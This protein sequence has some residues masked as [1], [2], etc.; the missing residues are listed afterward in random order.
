[1]TF[2]LDLLSAF[3]GVQLSM[4]VSPCFFPSKFWWDVCKSNVHLKK[5]VHYF[6]LNV[7]KWLVKLKDQQSNNSFI[8]WFYL[9]LYFFISITP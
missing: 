5:I 8:E 2:I 4:H 1:M 9:Y 3:L 7:V 6:F